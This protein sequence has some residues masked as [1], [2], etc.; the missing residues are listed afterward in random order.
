MILTLQISYIKAMQTTSNEN[1]NQ[2]IIVYCHALIAG[3]R[4]AHK[5]N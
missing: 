3:V 2:P 5:T 4:K 1:K